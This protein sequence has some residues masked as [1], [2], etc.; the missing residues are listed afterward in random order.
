VIGCGFDLDGGAAAGP[1]ETPETVAQGRRCGTG[2]IATPWRLEPSP[3]PEQE[4][5]LVSGA[6]V[7]AVQRDHAPT[8]QAGPEPDAAWGAMLRGEPTQIPADTEL[9]ILVDLC[10]YVCGYPR[11]ELEAGARSVVDIEWAESLYADPHPDAHS[12]K[13]HR[14][15]WAGKQWLGFGDRIRHPGGRRSYELP[16]WRSGRWLRFVIRT[17]DEPLFIRDARPLRTG[18]PSSRAYE[19][20]CDRPLSG[21]LELCERALRNCVH[22]TF[23]DCPYYEQLQYVG[24]TRIQALA[25]LVATGD[26]RPVRRALEL[27]DRSR[28]VNGFV[29]ERCP[30]HELQMSATY[31]LV[32]PP[33]LRDYAWWTADRATVQALLPG[34]RGSLEA[35]LACLDAEG[36][37]TQLPGWLFVDWV[38]RPD[39]SFGMPGGHDDAAASA[40]VA[41]HLPVALDAAAR[42]E[43]ACGDPLLARR[44]NELGARIF[45]RIMAA[46]WNADRGMLAD[47]RDAT[48]WSEHAQAL[49][50]DCSWLDPQR[51]RQLLDVLERPPDDLARASVYFS[52]HVHEA[53][54]RDGRVEAVLAR[55]GFWD[56]LAAQGFL[57]CVEAPEPARSDCHGWGAH[58]LYHCLSALAG[59]RPGAPFF[60]RARIAPQFGPLTRIRASVPHPGGAIKVE[61]ERTG[62]AVTGRII[63]PV[64]VDLVWAGV[65]RPLP[66]G[67]NR[68]S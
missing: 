36:L 31:S 24:D 8:V 26:P 60:Q 50:L 13:G 66:P 21:M 28:W 51:R 23:V 46:Y 19:F 22:E 67:E 53:L 52:H 49:A 43:S 44:W 47:N 4:R 35:A 16:W 59:I 33:M 27:F 30:S 15:E 6:A 14:A 63:S 11:I 38:A 48:R 65:T 37:P 64:P 17:A 25:W 5:T 29:A 34:M 56:A 68:L 7:R 10:D 42:V 20:E 41:L 12:P 9:Q 32:F 54:L 40:P 45:E 39:W 62:K 1:W 61:L 55:L 58:P 3:L 57:T 18:Y 2:E